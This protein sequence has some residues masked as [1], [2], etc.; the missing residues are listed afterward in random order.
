MAAVAD[1]ILRPAI[2]KNST[3]WLP[4]FEGWFASEL[5]TALAP[6]HRGSTGDPCRR[7]STRS[8]CLDPEPVS[9]VG[10]RYWPDARRRREVLSR[11]QGAATAEANAAR[12]DVPLPIAFRVQ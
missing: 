2:R 9:Q 7:Q 1:E 12:R 8:V 3:I 10:P 5:A 4:T 6:A 11:R